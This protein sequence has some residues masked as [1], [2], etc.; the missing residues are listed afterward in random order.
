LRKAQRGL[1][2][3]DLPVIFDLPLPLAIKRTDEFNRSVHPVLQIY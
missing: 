2:M 3:K 1:G